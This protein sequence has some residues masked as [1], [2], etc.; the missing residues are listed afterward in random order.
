[1]V[2]KP[3]GAAVGMVSAAVLWLGLTSVARPQGIIIDPRPHI[4]VA[5]S[6]EVRE[7]S[8]DV[9]IRDQVA[10]VQVAQT[11]HNPGSF[12]LEAEYFFPLP[13]PD[14]G[15]IQSFL[16]LV[17][18]K[19]MPG[20]ILPKDE[21]RRIYERIVRTK[22]DPALLEYMGRGLFRTSVFPIPPGADRKVTMRYTQLCKRDR[23]V[24][25]FSYPLSTQK[26]TAKPIRR[27][28]LAL[29]VESRDAIKSVYSPT[30]DVTIDRR[31]DHE[32]R[33]RLVRHDI[34]PSQ[35]F[36]LIYT[37]AEGTVGA[38]VLSHRPSGSDDGFFM[39]LASPE[40]RGPSIRPQAKTVIFV[41]DRS[42]SM[43]GKKIEQARKALHAVLNNLRDDDLFNIIVY[44]DRV[45][46]FKPE[47]QRYS[48]RTRNDAERF[49]DNIREGGSTN[50]DA[51]L[52]EALGMIRDDSRPSYVLF[53]TDGLPTAGET[54]ELNIAENCRKANR[55]K[56]RIFAFGVGYDVNARLLDRLSGGNH[57]ASEY[58]K[59]DEDIEA[60]VTRFDSKLTSPVLAD[61]RI[62]LEGIDV[63]R[64][65][66]RDIPDLFAGGQIVWVGRYRQGGRTTIRITGKVGQERQTMTFPVDLAEPGQGRSHEF[67][68][69]LWAVRRI[70]SIIDQ[71]DLNGQNKEL[72]DELVALSKTY[73]I[74]T[75][76]T[77]FLAEEDVPLHAMRDNRRRAESSLRMLEMEQS[78]QGGVAQR[79]FKQ[80]LLNSVRLADADLGAKA[81]DA[82]SGPAGTAGS[83]PAGR[84]ARKSARIGSNIAGYAPAAAAPAA[85]PIQGPASVA[86]NNLRQIGN[87]T[88]FRKGDHWVDSTI[89]PEDESKATT[90]EQFSEPYFALARTQSAEQNQYLTFAE[91]VVVEIEGKV[92]RIVPP[93]R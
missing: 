39:V 32:A 30:A 47:L 74:L 84:F 48:S 66:P 11:F 93:K 7:V 61:V 75:P 18:G 69:R 45:E 23:D 51:A 31:D 4:P 65:Y 14:E 58:V 68:D 81:L 21:A 38:T 29:R 53:L 70:G 34:I 10:E 41:L 62:E 33:A 83:Y 43:A 80:D 79:A 19:E 25:E 77:S 64:T 85:P 8:V 5:R 92:Y 55:S 52:Q 2:A 57:G 42:G 46:S 27:L 73:G 37:L 44:D 72:T 60:H 40:V 89:K 86:A 67:V 49:I 22:R 63:N 82:A 13:D 6:Y 50:I 90:I 28:E 15:A 59:P 16:L 78:G 36:R 71:I 1:M 26:V 54:R 3:S 20:R 17:D 24:V 12:V 56:A 91:T 35:D 88:F 87:K 9:R 76:Y